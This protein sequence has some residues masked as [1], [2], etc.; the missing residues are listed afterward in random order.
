VSVHSTTELGVD[1]AIVNANGGAIALGHP[2]G[3]SGTRIVGHLARRLAAVGSGAVG[4]AGICGG[5]GQGS[6]IVLEAL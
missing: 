5:G 6:A 4:A 2:I 1:P 3:A